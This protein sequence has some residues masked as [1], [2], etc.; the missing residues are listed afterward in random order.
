MKKPKPKKLPPIRDGKMHFNVSIDE[1]LGKQ[2]AE[3]AERENRTYP[4][5]LQ[6]IFTERYQRPKA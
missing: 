4:K 6:Q 2:F 1:H 3:E 5:Q